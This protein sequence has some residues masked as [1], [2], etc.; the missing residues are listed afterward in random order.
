MT[1]LTSAL[2][3][4]SQ[5]LAGNDLPGAG[6]AC[7]AALVDFPRSAELL[8]LLAIVEHRARNLPEAL[9]AIDRALEADPADAQSLNAKGVI[10]VA[11][12][13]APQALAAFTDALARQPDL[14]PARVNAG[15]AL[16]DLN[17]A[18]EALTHFDRA[19]GLAANPAE[20]AFHRGRAFEQ[21]G[22]ADE[23][24][25]SMTLAV[26]AQPR[27]AAARFMRAD[28]L[29]KA[30]RPIEALEDYDAILALSPDNVLALQNSAT[31]LQVH[32]RFAEASERH[33]R[34]LALLSSRPGQQVLYDYSL[35]MSV[36]C[37]RTA[38]LWSGLA[39]LE[40]R[41]LE[42]CRTGSAAL[43]P[44]L[45][46]MLTD[47]PAQ[48]VRI[49]QQW[50]L[51]FGAVRATTSATTRTAS[52]RLR[53]GYLS[54]DFGDHPTS[55]LMAGLFAAHDRSKFEV[56]GYSVRPN[57]RSAVRARIEATIEH[58][59]DL[60]MLADEA[61]AA[62]IAADGLDVLVDLNG[63]SDSGKPA[64]LARRPA[65]VIAHYLGYP[66]P[67]GTDI[68][69]YLI[70]DATVI[71]PDEDAAYCGAVAR[72]PGSYQINDRE[73]DPPAI[74]PPTRESCGLP[75]EGFVFAGFCQS[76]KLSA[77]VFDV[78]MEILRKT[79]G[80][81][82]WLTQHNDQMA[83]NLCAQASHR[84]VDSRRLVFAQR[85]QQA[86]H[87]ARHRHADLF[88]DTWPC[89]AHTSASDALWAGVPVITTPGRSF[90]SRVAA[91]VLQA[92]GLEELVV[93]GL[94]AYQDLAVALARSPADLLR[95]KEFIGRNRLTTSLFD[96]AGSCRAL[97]RA[98]LHMAAV[99]ASGSA[100]ASFQL[101][102]A[103]A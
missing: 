49:A 35:A 83:A 38:C 55:W 60:A 80:S 37:R 51:R 33:E 74:E 20:I 10:L 64:V 32:E 58:F 95:L 9:R 50:A 100:P 69:D 45:S 101:A 98:Y 39:A 84:G 11:M 2:R 48:L 92:I 47:D 56:F 13:R 73:R 18:A 28:L 24:L 5:R 67:L 42:R 54:A 43:K 77:S 25:A 93:D 85:V 76:L 40:E 103:G 34:A 27:F 4:V 88:L 79:P 17:R 14:V 46:L 65:A 21:L 87:M 52:S 44:F 59:V 86:E 78:W 36:S 53:V 15:N 75:A 97:E 41:L 12:D 29:R 81:V 62:R 90:A 3:D 22:R 102:D 8:R 63:W 6:D 30:G 94:A 16:L 91:S 99:R 61:M 19:A 82:L 72:L 31:L 23:A 71:R 96:T 89:G 1:E 7:R 57:D 70:A 68:Y 26:V 66:G